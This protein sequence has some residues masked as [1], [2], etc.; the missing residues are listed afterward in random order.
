MA[1]KIYNE[2]KRHTLAEFAALSGIS[3]AN[4]L[5]LEVSLLVDVLP[6]STLLLQPTELLTYRSTLI[7]LNI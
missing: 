4:L 2:D 6:T 1:L 3:A 5:E 7:S